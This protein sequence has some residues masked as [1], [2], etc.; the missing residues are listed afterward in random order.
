ML[1]YII[2]LF[3]LK[4]GENDKEKTLEAVKAETSFS[5]ARLW[6]LAC[7]ILIASVGLNVNST[8]VI[9]G[10]MLISPLMGPIVASGFALGIYDFALLKKSLNN[11]IVATIV[12]LIVSTLYFFLSPFKTAHSE[13]LART[14]PNIYDILIAF[15]GGLVGAIVVTR[16]EKGNPIAGVAIATALMPPLCTAG[17]GLSIGN[18][19]YF[20]GAFFLYCI[21]C[22]FICIAT[23][24]IVKY[25]GYLPAQQVNKKQ[26]RSVRTSIITIV[27][28]MLIPSV[29]FAYVLYKKEKYT[30]AVNTFVEN[31]LIANG[32]TIVYKKTDYNLKQLHL[33]FLTNGVTKEEEDNLKSKVQYYGIDTLSI[34][35]HHDSINN[36]A[37]LKNDLLNEIQQSGLAAKS[38][39][40]KI[41]SLQDSFEKNDYDNYSLLKEVAILF[42]QVKNIS[43]ANHKLPIN[44]DSSITLPLVVY[45]ASK[46]LPQ[47]EE[48]KLKK[49]LQQK[50]KLDTIVAVN[51]N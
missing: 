32:K 46:A 24:I 25:L 29:Y 21:N 27:S 18:F 20:F 14:S 43:L 30:E 13:L 41:L 15:F 8:A 36:F 19:S 17:Y 31:E 12:S 6:I 23:Y 39:Q 2:Y 42:P 7:A 49:W 45:K 1:R 28:L 16:T 5:G 37:S 51:N 44:K 35:I 38:Q 22:V 3:N 10:A 50:L 40:A 48:I 11:L 26:T 47:L 34:I 33:A 9:I 4:R